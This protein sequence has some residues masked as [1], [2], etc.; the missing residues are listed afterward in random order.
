MTPN[1]AQ[2]PLQETFFHYPL[3]RSIE[4]LEDAILIVAAVWHLIFL[5]GMKEPPDN[6]LLNRWM[7]AVFIFI[8]Y[9]LIKRIDF[10]D[11]SEFQRI[12]YITLLVLLTSAAFV[13]G[14]AEFVMPLY[15]VIVTKAVLLLH[16]KNV[17]FMCIATCLMLALSAT[18]RALAY[19][20]SIG[21]DR[22]NFETFLPYFGFQLSV[23]ARD[24]IILILV[25]LVVQTLVKA[26]QQSIESE[27][28]SRELASM[29]AD[30]ERSR[31]AREIHDGVGNS[32]ASLGVQL[33]VARKMLSKDPDKC[34]EALSRA[35]NIA[36]R[37][38]RDVRNAL[39]V[40][41]VEHFD[42]TDAVKSL[43]AEIE[44]GGK[45]TLVTKVDVPS[46]QPALAYQVFRV[47]QE[48]CI[49]AL[50][51]STGDK[52]ALNLH[53][54]N[55]TLFVEIND[56]GQG[57]N[58]GTTSENKGFGLLGIRERIEALHGSVEMTSPSGM[59]TTIKVQVPIDQSKVETEQSHSE[60]YD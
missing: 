19:E 25:A 56:N 30:L 54:T 43:A 17:G 55:G 14:I 27:R 20:P 18:V 33:E 29:N 40:M 57:L 11:R 36:R 3:Y 23:R 22:V 53:S 10:V 58:D 7:I 37:C 32:L 1:S 41:R 38:L 60:R 31:I 2:S 26:R 59:G 44:S 34:T 28:L 24:I 45:F 12:A 52:I 9:F 48:S 47:I 51:H 15:V 6:I 50:K 21:L 8:V 5:M 42:L 13:L 35:E 4:F 39:N 46:L 49:N 16:G